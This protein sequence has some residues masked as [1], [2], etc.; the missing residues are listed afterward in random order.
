MLIEDLLYYNYSQD[1]SSHIDSNMFVEKLS[2]SQA[3]FFHTRVES[4]MIELSEEE[5]HD[6][7]DTMDE[8]LALLKSRDDEANIERAST[9]EEKIALAKKR[10][11]QIK[12]V[13][14]GQR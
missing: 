5:Y 13:K 11:K 9:L 4:K 6:L 8:Y 2:E 14:H 12:E 3:H 1:G 10:D 7:I